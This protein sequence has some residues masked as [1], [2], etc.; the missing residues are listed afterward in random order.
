MSSKSEGEITDESDVDYHPRFRKKNCNTSQDD[1]IRPPLRSRN[2]RK[3]QLHDIFG[4]D[5]SSPENLSRQKKRRNT[6]RKK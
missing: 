2:N 5:D 1:D 4:T 6:R 3:R